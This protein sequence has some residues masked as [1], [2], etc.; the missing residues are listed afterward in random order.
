MF[1]IVLAAVAAAIIC[2]PVPAALAQ[3]NCSQCPAAKA[4]PTC[5]ASA[6][7]LKPAPVVFEKLP[8]FEKRCK[9]PD[10]HTFTY[11][12]DKKPKI[13]VAVLKVVLYNKQGVKDKTFQITGLSG[14]PSMGNAHDFEA[15]FKIN[16][17]GEYLLPVN[18]VMPG[19]WEVKLT[20][21]KD[22]KAVYYGAFTFRV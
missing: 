4:C 22:G 17:K 1:R 8:G 13:G 7:T 18:L 12:F 5:V 6:D 14:M 15:P 10:G 3:H 16:K 2:L 21:K 9:M 11:K 20:F 19:E